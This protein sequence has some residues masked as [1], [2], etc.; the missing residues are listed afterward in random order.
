MKK[1]MIR[2][3]GDVEE[4]QIGDIKRRILFSPTT[5][6]NRYIKLAM[7]V[8]EPRAQAPLHTHPGD[9]AAFTLSGEAK[10]L[11]DDVAYEVSE[12]VAVLVPPGVSHSAVCV[13]KEKWIVISAY[14][15]ECPLLRD[16]KKS[17]PC[18]RES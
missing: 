5:T 15:D 12:G 2:S 14:C 16:A 18:E 3:L 8:A 17:G 6:G 4:E 1:I 13:G 9:E 10:L 7:A 11:V